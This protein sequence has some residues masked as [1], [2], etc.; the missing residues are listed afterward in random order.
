MCRRHWFAAL[1]LAGVVTLV[2]AAPATIDWLELVPPERRAGYDPA[3]PPAI[4]DY[5][6]GESGMAAAQPLDDSV[7]PALEGKE[8]RI[9]GFVVPLE[10]DATGKATEFF[11]VPYFGACIHVPPP[12]PNQMVYVRIRSGLQLDSMYSAY[13]ISGRMAL[14]KHRTGLGAAAYTLT[15]TAI[16][17]YRF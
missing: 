8:V 15:A 11:L 14:R 13:W 17:E 9:P 4:H 6:T 16:E 3:P 7:N 5:L 12:S 10:L 1:L 2:T